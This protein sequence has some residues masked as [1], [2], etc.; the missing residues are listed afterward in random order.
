MNDIVDMTD[1]FSMDCTD[2]RN[3]YLSRRSPQS[4]S[5][6]ARDAL[7]PGDRSSAHPGESRPAETDMNLSFTALVSPRIDLTC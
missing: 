3:Q 7:L 6:P 2:I 5:P 4:P 1:R